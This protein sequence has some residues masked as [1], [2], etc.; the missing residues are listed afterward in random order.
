MNKIESID[1]LGVIFGLTMLVGVNAFAL[2]IGFQ[3]NKKIFR[4]ERDGALIL[5]V[6]S[7]YAISVVT[8]VILWSNTSALTS[9]LVV[10]SAMLLFL[11][12]QKILK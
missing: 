12:S 1:V 8:F 7:G 6:L 4:S 11:F 2:W 9:F 3:A 5:C 10:A